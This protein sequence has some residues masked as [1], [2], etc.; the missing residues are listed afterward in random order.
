MSKAARAFALSSLPSSPAP[1]PA[2]ALI[3]FLLLSLAMGVFSAAAIAPQ[4]SSSLFAQVDVEGTISAVGGEIYSLDINISIPTSTPYQIVE[5]GEQMKFDEFGNGYLGMSIKNPANP[6]SYSKKIIVQSVA[7]TTDFLPGSYSVPSTYRPYM[8]PTNRT[9]SDDGGIRA[10]AQNITAGAQTPFERVALLAIYVNRNME[11]VDSMVG[12]E[13]DA[14]W[15][16]NNMRGVCTEYST[17]FTA[18][19]RSIGIPTRYLS[20]YVYSDK[21]KAWMGHS[22]TEAYIGKWVPVDPTW[23]EV[24]ALDAMHIEESRNAEF[25]NRD[26]ISASV[27]SPGTRLAWDTGER[28]G[29]VAGNIRTINATYQEELGEFGLFSA[30]NS[31]GSR[32]STIAYL[33][34]QGTDFRVIPLSLA[35]C[36]GTKSLEFDDGE[37]YMVLE[38]GKVSTVVWEI[39]ASDSLSQNYIYSCP[40]MLNSPFLERRVL[41]ISVDPSK[42]QLPIF[43]ASLQKSATMPLEPNSVLLKVPSKL[44]GKNFTAVL[45]DGIYSVRSSGPTA[46][47]PFTSGRQGTVEV[48]V[49]CEEGGIKRLEYQSGAPSNILISAFQV[50]ALL[51]A[52]KPSS[53]I[54]NL[55]SSSYPSDFELD[56]SF[57]GHGEK[58]VGVLDGPSSFSFNFTPSEPGT[59]S[60]LLAAS[61]GGFQKT[62]TRLSSV[63][64]APTLSIDHVESVYSNG[65]LYTRVSFLHTGNPALPIATING[66]SYSAISTLTLAL[67]LGEQELYLSWKDAAGNLYSSAQKITV[68]QPGMFQPSSQGCPMALVLLFAAFLPILAKR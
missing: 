56:F 10:L 47:I 42:P 60:A 17:L 31:L 37:R 38:P 53:A 59:H 35:N 49:S 66:I 1:K 40:I 65:T 36:V 16:K 30:A 23:F 51:V 34:M 13:K 46:E 68:T 64:A 14:V 19:A 48:Y 8:L 50:P 21:F 2:R 54:A 55:S 39:K 32:A 25:S 43:E 44:R 7:R 57:A 63:I 22:W 20:G 45:P 5:A 27:S 18:L 67:P 6:V 33:S 9:Q 12:Q 62:E 15:V 41:T 61:S 29:A 28:S 4:L 26:R 3:V 52:G 11:Y 58:I 24:G